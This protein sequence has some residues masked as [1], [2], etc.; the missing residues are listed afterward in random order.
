MEGKLY[1]LTQ[2]FLNREVWGIDAFA[3]NATHCKNF[4][5]GRFGGYI[6]STYVE[7]MFTETLSNYL[8]FAQQHLR[9]AVPL[10]LEA[11]LTGIKGYPI[12]VEH[13]MPGQLLTNHVQWTGTVPSYGIAPHEILRPFFDYMCGSWRCS[14]EPATRSP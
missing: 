3:V 1:H 13:G 4:K 2:L 9:L 10:Q 6:P 12:A 11:G 5:E 7:R 8:E 14:S